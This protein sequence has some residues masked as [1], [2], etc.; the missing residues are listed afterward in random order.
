MASI[1]TPNAQIAPNKK[2]WRENLS[3]LR[4][5]IAQVDVTPP[6]GIESGVWG[7]SKHS[8]SESVHHGLFVTALAQQDIHGKISYI[9]GADLCVLGCVEC[10]ENLLVNISTKLNINKDDLLFSSSHSHSTPLPCIHRAHK[11][12]HELVPGF[13]EQ[14]VDGTVKACEEA[15]FN[16]QDVNVTWAYGKCD[17]AVNRDLPCGEHGGTHEVVAFN[18]AILADDTL[19]VG[20]IADK[21]GEVVGTIANYA[22]HPTTLA[23]DNRAISP[24]YIG[25]ARELVQ[26]ETG[27]PMLFL[28]G[29]SGELSPRDQY[30]GETS[31]ADKNGRNLGHSI[32]ATLASMQSPGHELRWVG[33]VESGALLG[34]WR[35]FPTEGSS[36]VIKT[37]LDVKV[38]VKELKSIDQLRQEW[39]GIDSDALEERISR[40][41]RLRI[42]Y[43]SKQITSHPVWIWQ[44]G[45][46]IFVAQPG[47]AYSY[48]QTELRRRNPDRVIFVMNLTNYPGLFYLPIRS[49]YV[50]PAYQAWQTLLAPG[51]I[52]EVVDVTDKFIKESIGKR[53]N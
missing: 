3:S 24:D 39:A 44:L 18:P 40:A 22:C 7:A 15:S 14:L 34:E 53:D 17:L 21:N 42:G 6:V 29:A 47:E 23:W 2:I 48:L 12:G 50:A 33:I 52:E 19:T 25:Q 36:A 26:K 16:I 27:A 37:R 38:R 32:L 5:G 8:R 45:D 13:I 1:D 30:S 46:A 11:D 51:A 49:A 28:Q 31:L 9:T 20:R 4:L 35:E 10:A 43:E 41:K